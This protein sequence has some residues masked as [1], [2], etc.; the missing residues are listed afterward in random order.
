[1]GWLCATQ[2]KSEKYNVLT[3]REETTGGNLA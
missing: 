2:G 3:R 1:M